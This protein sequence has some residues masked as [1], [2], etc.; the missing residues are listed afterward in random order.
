VRDRQKFR[1]V[2]AAVALIS[3]FRASEPA[4]FKWK[5]P[6]YEYEHERTPI[7]VLA[8]STELR[9]QIEGGVGPAEIARSWE[10]DVAEFETIRKKFLLY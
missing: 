4:K 8:G 3:A 7:D 10:K 5:D 2:A 1:P 6:P 9:E